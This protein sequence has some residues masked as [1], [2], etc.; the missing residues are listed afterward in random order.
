[1]SR[2]KAAALESIPGELRN[3]TKS[4]LETVFR[5]EMRRLVKNY[6]SRLAVLPLVNALMVSIKVAA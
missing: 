3:E 5:H 2:N 6:S 4:P 1:M